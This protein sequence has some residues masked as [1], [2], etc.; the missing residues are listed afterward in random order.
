M[1]SDLSNFDPA[2]LKNTATVSFQANLEKVRN[3]LPAL[4]WWMFKEVMLTVRLP[5][6]ISIQGWEL[7]KEVKRGLVQSNRQPEQPEEPRNLT[8]PGNPAEPKQPEI[9]YDKAMDSLTKAI[10]KDRWAWI[11]KEAKRK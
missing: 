6:K 8:N 4:A 11:N 2:G 5:Y 1:E 7:S 9:R 10:E 3:Q